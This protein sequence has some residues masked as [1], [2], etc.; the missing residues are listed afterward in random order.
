MLAVKTLHRLSSHEDNCLKLIEAG[1]IRALGEALRTEELI[2]EAAGALGFLSL[3]PMGI[4]A[5]M[6]DRATILVLLEL[7]NGSLKRKRNATLVFIL[8]CQWHHLGF[9]RRRR[10]PA[11][12]RELWEARI[13]TMPSQVTV[14]LMFESVFWFLVLGNSFFL[15]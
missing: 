5:I 12:S 11:N 2:E 8:L 4:E 1:A 7:Q 9:F 13:I 15:V 10:R 6:A 14:K 3:H